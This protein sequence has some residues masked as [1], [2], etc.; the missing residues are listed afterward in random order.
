MIFETNGSKIVALIS[1]I[2]FSSFTTHF[3]NLAMHLFIESDALFFLNGRKIMAP[4][5]KELTYK[6][7]SKSIK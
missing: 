2:L 3:C 6:E 7:I 1:F 5:L 4:A